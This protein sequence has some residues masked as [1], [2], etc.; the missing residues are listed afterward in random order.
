MEINVELERQRR[1]NIAKKKVRVIKSDQNK[2]AKDFSRIR[3][4]IS[5]IEE[6]TG[7]GDPQ[8]A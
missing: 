4:Q 3:Q 6:K 7:T 8:N 2:I 1:I 5:G